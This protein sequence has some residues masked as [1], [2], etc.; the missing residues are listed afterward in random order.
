MLAAIALGVHFM[1]HA[2]A[3]PPDRTNRTAEARPKKQLTPAEARRKRWEVNGEIAKIGGGLGYTSSSVMWPQTN[4]W[5]VCDPHDC[6]DVTAGAVAHHRSI[7][8]FQ[9]SRYKRPTGTASH[10][11][12]GSVKIPGCGPVKIIDAPLGH[13]VMTWAQR[14]GNLR[15]ACK[16]TGATGTL[17]LRD[18]TVTLDG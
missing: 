10:L 12:G 8:W 13:K 11:P 9:V 1:S 4:A 15:F 17:H 14:R 6:T 7:G 2:P 18:V 5:G 16:A 3:L